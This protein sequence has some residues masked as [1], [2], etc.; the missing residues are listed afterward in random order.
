MTILLTAIFFSSC[1]LFYTDEPA[2]PYLPDRT[3]V[4]DVRIY[5]YPNG[6]DD[7]LLASNEEIDFVIAI[8]SNATPIRESVN[9]SPN[10]DDLYCIQILAGESS[11]RFYLYKRERW[12]GLVTQW[13]I[14]QPYRGIYEISEEE[15]NSLLKFL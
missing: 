11:T 3:E 14:E 2:S 8:L 4:T 7:T 5:P 1:G 10:A 15:A 9:D 13:Y 6:N 12:L